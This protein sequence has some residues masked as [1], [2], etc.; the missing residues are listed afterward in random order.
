MKTSI[1][2]KVIS[3]L[4]LI[5][6]LFISIGAFYGGISFLIA[7]DGHLMGLSMDAFK[8]KLFPDFLI[9]GIMLI[10]FFG[11]IPLY[12]CLLII[13]KHMYSARY[14]RYLAYMLLIWLGVQMVTLMDI[15]GLHIAFLLLSACIIFLSYKLTLE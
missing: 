2:S 6:L 1:K 7:P 9:P 4:L 13:K 3:S 12:I 5:M 11:L 10:I 14:S 15:A 8:I